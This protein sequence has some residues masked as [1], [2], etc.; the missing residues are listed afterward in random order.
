VGVKTALFPALSAEQGEC[1]NL[2][3]IP[4]ASS[5]FQFSAQRLV[6]SIPQAAIDLPREAMCTAADVG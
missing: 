6:L 1:V 2:Q 3:A 4:Q 5:D